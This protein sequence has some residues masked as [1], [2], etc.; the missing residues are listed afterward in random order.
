[1]ISQAS[2]G[3]RC[4]LHLRQVGGSLAYTCC[5]EELSREFKRRKVGSQCAETGLQIQPMV[6]GGASELSGVALS[7]IL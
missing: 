2:N 5:Q 7:L 6:A 1:M 3:I 4:N